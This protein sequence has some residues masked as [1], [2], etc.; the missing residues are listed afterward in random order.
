MAKKPVL[1][2][3]TA[4]RVNGALLAL[5]ASKLAA[6]AKPDF[7][8]ILAGVT[9][10]NFKERK[11]AILK[12][13]KDSIESMLTPEATA[14][15]GA[16]P[17]DVIMRVLDLVDAQTGGMST[18]EVDAAPPMATAPNGGVPPVKEGAEPG[19]GSPDMGKIMEF[20]KGKIGDDDM[21]ELT[22]MVGGESNADDGN[23]PKIPGADDDDDEKKKAA[24]AAD[25]AA[26]DAEMKDLVPKSAM[27]AAIKKASE[28]TEARVVANQR[29][30]AEAVEYVRPW[31]GNINGMA[32]DSG[33]SVMRAALKALNVDL[34]DDVHD[35]AL[36]PILSA[37]PKP[38]DRKTLTQ[39]SKPVMDAAAGKSFAE[40]YPHA[41]SIGNLG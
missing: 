28:D 1:M 20:L 29:G 25:K 21:T 2:T 33:A 22:N 32:H 38:S 40:R 36:K 4:H 9:G 10:K 39:D 15:G 7:S 23:E 8:K 34:G 30:I 18:P 35:S 3:G 11:P 24:A 16:G 41:A 26:K 19:G 6:D 5:F 27:D 37:Q 31:V 17:D 12:G 13:A 14:G